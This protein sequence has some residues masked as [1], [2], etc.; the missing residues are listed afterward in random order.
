MTWGEMCD[1]IASAIAAGR[2]CI[3]NKR[4]GQELKTADEIF[5]YSSTGELF[6]IPF[7]YYDWHVDKRPFGIH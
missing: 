5:N 2:Y 4:T 3:R 1:E 6:K 7:W